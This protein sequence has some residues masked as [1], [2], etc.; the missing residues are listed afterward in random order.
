MR[1]VAGLA[2]AAAQPAGRCGESRRTAS[3]VTAVRARSTSSEPAPAA[4]DAGAA[5]GHRA[6]GATASTQRASLVFS[7]RVD[8]ATSRVTLRPAGGRAGVVNVADDGSFRA[9][10]RKLK[11]GVNRFVLQGRAAGLVPWKVDIEITRR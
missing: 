11:R 9:R 10:A 3:K 7:G 1:R 5:A 2:L 4:P 6:P 8:P